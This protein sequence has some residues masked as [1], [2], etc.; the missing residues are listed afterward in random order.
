M[1]PHPPRPAA[2]LAPLRAPFLLLLLFHLRGGLEL[3]NLGLVDAKVSGRLALDESLD[4]VKFFCLFTELDELQ[5]DL[6]DALH[7][8]WDDLPVAV[9]GGSGLGPLRGAEKVGEEVGYACG[10]FGGEEG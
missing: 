4:R 10:H 9:Q 2:H 7:E 8:G 1:A 3:E 5:V 6:L